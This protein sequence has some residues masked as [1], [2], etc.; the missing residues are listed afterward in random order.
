MTDLFITGMHKNC[1]N[2]R[3]NSCFIV[4]NDLSDDELSEI[5]DNIVV[6]PS[7]ATLR[8]QISQK[9]HD[10]FIYNQGV[11]NNGVA[12]LQTFNPRSLYV[13]AQGNLRMIHGETSSDVPSTIDQSW[14]LYEDIW[15][16]Q[17]NYFLTFAQPSSVFLSLWSSVD[18]LAKYTAQVKKL[19]NS[20]SVEILNAGEVLFVYPAVAPY[21]INS[22]PQIATFISSEASSTQDFIVETTNTCFLIKLTPK[23]Q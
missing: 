11:T 5:A 10:L 18:I 15:N 17:N 6:D 4:I 1:I 13:V 21:S 7:K 8:D 22:V 9:R 2:P 14:K 3:S 16:Y 12:V 23:N 20:S 19:Q